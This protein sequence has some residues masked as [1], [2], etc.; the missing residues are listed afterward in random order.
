MPGNSQAHLDTLESTE[1]AGPAPLLSEPLAPPPP[2]HD[3]FRHSG[4]HVQRKA[5]YAAFLRLGVPYHR[6]EAFASCGQSCWV[7]RKSDDPD[8]FK[9]V[10]DYCH[11]RLCVPCGL[12]RQSIIR[13]NLARHLPAEP[14]R[15]LTLTVRHASEPLPHLLTKLLTSFRRLRRAAFW[16]ERVTGGIACVEVTYNDATGSWHPHLHAILAGRYLDLQALSAA[17]LSATGDSTSVKIKLIRS[18]SATIKYVAKYVTKPLPHNVVHCPD[19]LDHAITALHGRKLVI[20][21]GTWAR[22]R[23][24]HDDSEDGWELYE[25]WAALHV[26]ADRDDG[27]PL[28]ILDA[29]SNLE[30]GQREFNVARA[31]PDSS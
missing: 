6:R 15:F 30:P 13:R 2:T 23:L 5:V 7:L 18:Q 19:A 20:A 27:L 16:K 8:R 12:L 25:H 28:A 11:D 21:F 4:W 22:W 1:P 3:P 14:H 31:P 10:S 24:L 29:I 17:W 26:M 9:L